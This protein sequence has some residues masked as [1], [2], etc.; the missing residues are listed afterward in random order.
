MN[1]TVIAQRSRH[2]H[3]AC[4]EE[5]A[6]RSRNIESETSK[7]QCAIEREAQIEFRRGRGFGVAPRCEGGATGRAHAWHADLCVGER[8]CGGKEAVMNAKTLGRGAVVVPPSSGDVSKSLALRGSQSRSPEHRGMAQYRHLKNAPI[9]EALVDLR[10]QSSRKIDAAGL[11]KL[12]EDLG[13]T[14]VLKGPIRVG[15]VNFESTQELAVKVAT[16]ELG[17]R[18]HSTDDKFVAQ[19]QHQGFTLSR[20]APYTDW[21]HLK[22][23]AERLWPLY[24]KVVKPE[25]VIRLA[26]RYINNLNLRMRPGQEFSEFLTA[27]PDVPNALPQTLMS[28]MQRVVIAH[29]EMKAI[30]ILTQLLEPNAAAT[31]DKVP[32][33]LDVDVQCQEQFDPDGW[34]SQALRRD[35]A[36]K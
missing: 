10:V 1:G 31:I 23:E 22:R 30:T 3:S 15:E 13:N 33:I 2:L 19:F 26:C 4:I 21:T 7:A 28:F 29:P 18:F 17:F 12:T 6:I 24:V 27:A 20:L 11:K 35:Q 36:R 8:P 9:T 32:V 14:Y 16:Q 25:R 5:A 34:A